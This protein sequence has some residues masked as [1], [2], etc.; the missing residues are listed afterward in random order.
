MARIAVAGQG[1]D[2]RRHEI[3]PRNL[4]RRTAVLDECGDALEQLDEAASAGVHDTGGLQ[5]LDLGG[6][7][8]EGGAAP[9]QPELEAA[10]KLRGFCRPVPQAVGKRLHH[11]QDR[12]LAG[13]DEG[14]RGRGRRRGRRR[15]PGSERSAR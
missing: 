14:P 13:L 11:A 3:L 4:D 5:L 8:R 7:L 1:L 2:A 15:G 6:R 12:A 9:F 10:E